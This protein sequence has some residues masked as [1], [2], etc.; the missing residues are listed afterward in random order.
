LSH[1]LLF[2]ARLFLLLLRADD[3]LAAGARR[4]GCR[5]C[6]GVLHSAR[7]PRKPRG[8][9]PAQLKAEYFRRDSFCCANDDCRKR[10][11]PPSLRFLGRRVYLGAIV[12]L[13]SAMTGGVTLKRAAELNELVGVSMRT[14]Q[15]WR[16]WWRETFAVSPFWKAAKALF[17]P[18][19]DAHGAP[20]TLIERF[21]GSARDKLVAC[22]KFLAPITTRPGSAMAG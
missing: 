12:V 1:T 9:P 16:A 10:S 2:D 7:Y 4:D 8:G 19:V 13:T 15:R 20:S 11:T 6:G 21:A 5:V 22:L 3:D 17:S 14:L 18:P